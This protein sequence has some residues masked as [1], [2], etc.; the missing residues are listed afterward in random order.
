MVT[1]VDQIVKYALYISGKTFIT[2]ESSL[3]PV[4]FWSRRYLIPQNELQLTSSGSTGNGPRPRATPFNF[5]IKRSYYCQVLLTATGQF[6]LHAQFKLQKRC[7]S[8]QKSR[9]YLKILGTR[10][11]IR[12]EYHTEDPQIFSANV[13]CSHGDLL[14]DVCAPLSLNKY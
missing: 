5:P 4:M 9:S 11:V 12:S 6:Y 7:K 8:S 2:Q 1:S 10:W 3:E 13:F 14:P